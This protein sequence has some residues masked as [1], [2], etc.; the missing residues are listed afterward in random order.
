[1]SYVQG[2]DSRTNILLNNNG[3]Q[4][5]EI[6]IICWA[7]VLLQ[8]QTHTYPHGMGSE[9]QIQCRLQSLGTLRL[10]LQGE[11]ELLNASVE[12]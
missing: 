7:I 5:D 10:F 3:G 11:L 9:L 1:M 12:I 4:S 8:H 2:V 6:H